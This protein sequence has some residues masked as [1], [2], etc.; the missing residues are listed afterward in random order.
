[1]DKEPLIP[2]AYPPSLRKYNNSPSHTPVAASLVFSRKAAPLYLPRLD[3]HLSSFPRTVLSES[4][5]DGKP[6]MFPPMYQLAKTG[7]TIDDLEANSS[8]A[9]AWRNRKTILGS[10]VNA[11]IGLLGSSALASFYSLQGLI[12]TVQVFALILSTIVPLGGQNVEDKWRKLFLGTI[13][14][15]LALNFASTL[16]QSLLF[17]IIFMTIA[18]LL[19]YYFHVSTGQCDRYNS[20]EGLQQPETKGKQW[21]LVIVTFLLTVIYLPLSTMAVH[22]LVWSEDLW[23]VPNPYTNTTTYP[24]DVPLLGPTSEFRD[25]LD[26]CWTT[27]MRRNEVNYA[28]IIIILSAIVAVFLTV[29]FPMVLRRV[30]R[31]SVPK[32]DKFTELGRPRNSIDMDGEY[33]RLLARDK[34]PF[35][36]LYGGFRRGWGTYESTYLFAKLSTLV[37]I[38]VIDTDNCLFRSQSRMVIPVVRQVLLLLSTIGFFIAQCIFAPFLDPVNNAS[39]WTSRLNYVTTATTALAIAL[40]IPGKDII[41][42][43]VLYSIYIITYGLSIYFSAINL[44]I[45]Q[46]FVKI[47]T[48]RIDFSIDIFSPRLDIS[49][50]SLHTRRRIWQE[51]ITALLLTSPGCAIPKEQTMSF[52]QAR[53]SEFPPYLLSFQGSPGE[54]HVENLKILREVGSLAY[55]RAVALISGPD[56]AWYKYLED[57]IQKNY[58]GPDCYW[59]RPG[60]ESIPGCSNFFGHAWWIPFPPALVVIQYDEGKLVVLREV[61]DFEAYVAQNSD[62]TVEQKRYVRVSLRALEGQVVRWPYDHIQPVGSS[63]WF[64]GKHSYSATTSTNYRSCEL[65]IK[66]RG[67]L[68]W[69]NFQLGSG[70]AIELKYSR[71]VR[72]TGEV[73]GLNDDFDLTSPLACFLNLNQELIQKRIHTIEDKLSDYRRFCRKECRWKSKVLSYRFLTHVYNQPRDPVGLA[74]SSI[75]FERDIRVRELMLSSE[76]VFEAAY[77]RLS[78]VSQTEVA[79]WWYIFWDDLWRRNHDTISGLRKYE[80]DFNPHYPTSIAYTP[81]PRPVLESFLTQR[82]LLH[83][84]PKWRDFFHTGFLNKLYLRLNES[85]F[86]NSSQAI[87]F[88]IGN[89]SREFDMDDVDLMTQGRPSTLGTGGGTDHDDNWI[90]ARPAYRWEGLLSDPSDGYR[91]SRRLLAKLG[92][93]FGITPLWRAGGSSEGISLDLR[94]QNGRYILIEDETQYDS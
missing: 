90:R 72:V 50:S 45:T 57:E 16:V 54:R 56:F 91:G 86:R 88:H 43:Y 66:R 52:A 78:T 58:I 74:Q 35:A 39:E 55:S 65:T 61:V 3:T 36:F 44:N 89:D 76:A 27:T 67:H 93:W 32:V 31:E 34:N 85:V 60:S 17:L 13:P 8:P 25:P 7:K 6:K 53:D 79:T 41:D 23:I 4:F 77:K 5:E 48:R 83:R 80:T 46:R 20:I 9:P 15:V 28:P 30:I 29:W 40:N 63:R 87:M 81:L 37:V 71:S 42:T 2:H 73:I 62:P 1:M 14:N 51:S 70:F 47:M 19:L 26:F 94:L 75:E 18:A 59:K 68:V 82:D 49:S 22:V 64:W 11:V 92:A 84:I 24:P 21:G 69:N 12:N 38:A 10:A 33:H